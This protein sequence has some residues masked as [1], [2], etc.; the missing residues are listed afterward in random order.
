ITDS[1]NIIAVLDKLSTYNGNTSTEKQKK[2]ADILITPGVKTHSTLDFDNLD[3]LVQEGAA[4]AEELDYIL[5]NL[6]DEVAY[7]EIR[8]KGEKLV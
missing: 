6:S 7:N 8:A 5:K 4:A 3:S 2:L 1:S